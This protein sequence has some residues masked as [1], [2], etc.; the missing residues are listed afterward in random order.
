[1][2]GI[3][4]SQEV[5]QPLRLFDE[6][7]GFDRGVARSQFDQPGLEALVLCDFAL[8]K[9]ADL[10]QIVDGYGLLKASDQLA[11]GSAAVQRHQWRKCRLAAGHVSVNLSPQHATQG[12]QFWENVKPVWHEHNA[13][14]VV[15]I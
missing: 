6:R 9:R 3:D 15:D 11:D 2:E 1:M 5:L 13:I 7:S 12:D 14:L 10:L 8:A 4:D